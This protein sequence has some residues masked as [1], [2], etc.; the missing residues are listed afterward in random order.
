[1]SS[2][3]SPPSSSYGS[4]TGS[5]GGLTS[6]EYSSAAAASYEAQSGGGGTAAQYQ[7]PSPSAPSA[8]FIDYNNNNNNAPPPPQHAPSDHNNLASSFAQIPPFGGSQDSYSAPQ[9]SAPAQYSAPGQEQQYTAPGQ[10]QQYTAPQQDVTLE[11]QYPPQQ[12]YQSPQQEYSRPAAHEP[13]QYNAPQQQYSSPVESYS[14][15]QQE[16][17][18]NNGY[19]GTQQDFSSSGAYNIQP[20]IEI[21]SASFTSQQPVEQ[22]LASASQSYH[23]GKL[24]SRERVDNIVVDDSHV[25]A[26]VTTYTASPTKHTKKSRRRIPSHTRHV[27]SVSSATNK[28][29]H[30]RRRQHGS[31]KTNNSKKSPVSSSTT[32]ATPSID[33]TPPPPPQLSFPSS[34]A[35]AVLENSIIPVL[36]ATPSPTP[37]ESR[38]PTISRRPDLIPNEHE[39][40]TAVEQLTH[41]VVPIVR[42]IPPHPSP[43]PPHHPH[44][45][46]PPPLKKRTRLTLTLHAHALLLPH[47]HHRRL[48]PHL[49][50]VP[51]HPVPHL[52]PN[53]LVL[54]TNRKH[55]LNSFSFFKPKMFLP[56]RHHHRRP[57]LPKHVRINNNLLSRNINKIRLSPLGP[58]AQPSEHI[59]SA[60]FNPSGAGDARPAF[61]Y[62]TPDQVGTKDVFSVYETL[63]L[64]GRDKGSYLLPSLNQQQQQ[65]LTG[66]QQ[67]GNR[68]DNYNAPPL[69]N[70]PL[71]DYASPALHDPFPT[72]FVETSPMSPTQSYDNNNNN[73]V[74]P[75]QLSFISNNQVD[76]NQAY[77]NNDGP[78]PTGVSGGAALFNS[79]VSYQQQPSFQYSQEQSIE[80]PRQVQPSPLPT[81]SGSCCSSFPRTSQPVPNNVGLHDIETEYG[82]PSNIVNANSDPYATSSQNLH[83]VYRRPSSPTPTST[84]SVPAQ[85]SGESNEA[86]LT[87]TTQGKFQQQLDFEDEEMV[88]RAESSHEKH[89][90]KKGTKHNNDNQATQ[91]EEYSNSEASMDSQGQESGENVSDLERFGSPTTTI[92][93]PVSHL[94]SSSSNNFVTTTFSPSTTILP[95]DSIDDHDD[96]DDMVAASTTTTP[97]SPLL[98][99]PPPPPAIVV[100]PARSAMRPS[101][102]RRVHPVTIRPL[103]KSYLWAGKTKRKDT[104]FI[105]RPGQIKPFIPKMGNVSIIET[106]VK[107]RD[108]SKNGSTSLTKPTVFSPIKFGS[109]EKTTRDP[110][111]IFYENSPSYGN[112]QAKPVRKFPDSYFTTRQTRKTTTTSATTTS[113]STTPEPEVEE[114]E[115]AVIDDDGELVEVVNEEILS[116]ED[117]DILTED[118]DDETELEELEKLDENNEEP[119]EE[120]DKDLNDAITAR[121]DKE[122]NIRHENDYHN[123]DEISSSDEHRVQEAE[124]NHINSSSTVDD[125]DI[126]DSKDE[127]LTTAST[128]INA[129]LT[130]ASEPET[131]TTN[132]SNSDEEDTRLVPSYEPN[133]R[134]RR[135]KLSHRPSGPEAGSSEEGNNASIN[136]SNNADN[137]VS[138]TAATTANTA[139][140]ESRN[141][142]FGD[143]NNDSSYKNNDD[144]EN[145]YDKNYRP[146]TKP[147]MIIEAT[148][149][150]RTTF[151]P[152]MFRRRPSGPTIRIVTIPTAKPKPK[153]LQPWALFPGIT[154]TTTTAR[155]TSAPPPAPPKFSMTIGGRVFHPTDLTTQKNVNTTTAA[156]IKAIAMKHKPGNKPSLSA[157][158]KK[159]RK[160]F[161]FPRSTTPPTSPKPVVIYVHSSTVSD[162]SYKVEPLHFV[163]FTTPAPEE[164][165]IVSPSPAASSEISR[166]IDTDEPQDD[167][168]GENYYEEIITAKPTIVTRVTTTTTTTAVTTTPPPPQTT[169]TTT[170]TPKPIYSV[171]YNPVDSDEYGVDEVNSTF[172]KSHLFHSL[173]K[174]LQEVRDNNGTRSLEVGSTS[175]DPKFGYKLYLKKK[176]GSDKSSE[177]VKQPSRQQMVIEKERNMTMTLFQ[178]Q[179]NTPAKQ[180]SKPVEV[181][182]LTYSA[183]SGQLTS[184]AVDSAE[185]ED[186]EELPIKSRQNRAMKEK[187]RKMR[188]LRTLN[189]GPT[190]APLRTVPAMR[191]SFLVVPQSPV[192]QKSTPSPSAAEN[193][194]RT[195]VIV[196]QPMKPK[197]TLPDNIP[198]ASQRTAKSLSLNVSDSITNKNGTS[199]MPS[200]FLVAKKAQRYTQTTF[201]NATAVQK[202]T[203][204]SGSTSVTSGTSTNHERPRNKV[205]QLIL[206]DAHEVRRKNRQR[207]IKDKVQQIIHQ[208]STSEQN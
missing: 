87:T 115:P 47:V 174:S 75:T 48:P 113:T 139:Y 74:G 91:A 77:N 172:S 71:P 55:T 50:H 129:V 12:E 149:V 80:Q 111:K 175:W 61:G 84:T 52:P 60:V 156:T 205:K 141:I 162:N 204:S 33:I 6:S 64:R 78:S 104:K 194:T 121:V 1:M 35:V 46:G 66:P 181:K 2:Y 126:N 170:T 197:I 81:F 108:I 92:Q 160:E 157:I 83:P 88:A 187:R 105:T 124:N 146:T 40:N 54:H 122:T 131:E 95:P 182:Y 86:D 102:R 16:P 203:P 93:S 34:T 118:E 68:P 135:I 107:R 119:V 159:R 120:T 4:P 51:L 134:R 207:L 133:G 152:Q 28:N 168:E 39:D 13:P 14:A 199:N 186:E 114:N 18:N 100:I 165:Q 79:D 21:S 59:S 7:S 198:L 166:K 153:L 19:S 193:I 57:P 137:D 56:N 8:A 130:R 45:I 5:S 143:S 103:G 161:R 195:V 89:K 38:L 20:A 15:P 82:Q 85:Q 25:V 180:P 101:H 112:K 65:Q 201:F 163:Q 123:N 42:P 9:L 98:I 128:D 27:N 191:P 97:S 62:G 94:V 179:Q 147:P 145:D 96:D 164:T 110:M 37:S 41:N 189:R 125:E 127:P 72:S 117:P 44:P 200:S 140:G 17:I 73:N 109:D 196:A 26:T 63:K 142:N 183:E 185:P 53:K 36:V 49:P 11:Q 190:A 10:E 150:S 177:E 167:E 178:N 76:H 132:N 169:L 58:L 192:Y 202:T 3:G 90:T 70:N 30:H 208:K 136:D 31:R 43:F 99:S 22:S 158:L 206:H 176:N 138:A 151:R 24:N 32:I 155:T 23:P 144:D 154:S 188:R 29:R 106:D 148:P 173:E 171:S 67:T 184:D 116:D 69:S